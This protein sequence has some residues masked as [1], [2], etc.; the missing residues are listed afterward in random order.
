MFN[1]YSQHVFLFEYCVIN[2]F[3]NLVILLSI[4]QK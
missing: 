4:N 3:N 1:I 2:N